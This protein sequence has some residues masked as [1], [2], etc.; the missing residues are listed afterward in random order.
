MTSCLAQS[1]T[2][3]MAV[4]WSF[5]TL[6][7]FQQTTCSYSPEDRT[8]QHD[9]TSFFLLRNP[10]PWD[11]SLSTETKTCG[12]T[13]LMTMNYL[14]S[15]LL[16]NF[17]DCRNCIHFAAIPSSPSPDG[18]IYISLLILY[19]TSELLPFYRWLFTLNCSQSVIFKNGFVPFSFPFS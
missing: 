18:C 5:E 16:E 7:Y 12:V 3:K 15:Q 6:A 19:F 17:C 9:I 4:T 13:A 1:P 2:V 10:T 14:L 8:L 11:I